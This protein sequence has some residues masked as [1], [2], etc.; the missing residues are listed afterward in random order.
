MI[1]PEEIDFIAAKLRLDAEQCRP[2]SRDAMDA[3]AHTLEG[4]AQLQR[5]AIVHLPRPAIVLPFHRPRLVHRG[6]RA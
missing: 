4:W 1:P 2:L 3:L 6:A 5:E